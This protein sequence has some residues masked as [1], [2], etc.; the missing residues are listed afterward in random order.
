MLQH[1]IDAGGE[2]FH[3]SLA[4]QFFRFHARGKTALVF[5]PDMIL[6]GASAYPRIIDFAQFRRIADEVR[7]KCRGVSST[8]FARRGN[9]MI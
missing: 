3:L 4:C 5:R 7:C 9:M 8:R 6:C 2:W 1:A